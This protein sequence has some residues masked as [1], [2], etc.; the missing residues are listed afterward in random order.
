MTAETVRESAEE[1]DAIIIGSGMTGGW[2]AKE[3]CEKG[4]RTL[5]IERGRLVE[6]REDYI[7]EGKPPW[8]MPHRNKVAKEIV[9]RDYPVQ[10]KCYALSDSS[11]HFFGND[12]DLPYST[13]DDAPFAWIRANQ[14]GGKSV[15]WARQSYRLSDYDFGA[16]AADGHGLDWPIRYKDLERWYDYVETFAG[17]SGN[18][19]GLEQLPDMQCQPPFDM[20]APELAFKQ[21]IEK[22]YSDRNVIIGRTANLTKPTE[23]Q[24]SLGRVLCQARDQCMNGCSFGAYFSTLSATLPAAARTGNLHI[25][26][27][28]V[29]HS[30]VYDEQRQRVRGVRVIDNEDLSEREYTGRVV[31]LCASTLGSTQ[32][33]LNSMSKAFPKGLANRSGVLGHFLMDH[34]YNSA[35]HAK[36]PGYLDTYYKGR[37]PTGILVPNFHYKPERYAKDFVR[38]YQVGGTAY[39]GGWQGKGWRDGFGESFKAGIN[40]AGDWGFSTYSMGEMLPDYDNQVSLHPT[41]KDKWGIPQ[42]HI[43]CRWSDNEKRMMEASV[44]EQKAMLEAAGFEDVTARLR[45]E[46]PGLAIHEVGSARMG[47]DPK[48]SVFNGWNQAHDVPNLFCTDGST[49]CST[50]TQN[51]S[52]TFMALTARAVDYAAREMKEK[53]I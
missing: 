50:A 22:Q 41:L 16:N 29:V 6:H 38:G 43:E 9:D 8:E 17:I 35:A 48:E 52:L 25:A 23:L 37:R 2:A 4:F 34:N 42:L 40:Q 14:L 39:R 46:E 30:L 47:R 27:N 13:P 20:S 3:F 7:G 12:R 11:K 24:M 53:R 51:P 1:Y 5:M 26:P 33:L 21:A 32:I 10:Q 19:D 15:L 18:R 36:V 45:N 44:V 28:S 31:F 49:F